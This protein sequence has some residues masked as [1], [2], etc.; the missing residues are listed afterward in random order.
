M[1]KLLALA[2]VG[3]AAAGVILILYPPIVVQLLFGA[4]I[5]GVGMAM[6]RIAGM[7]LLG[8]GVACWPGGDAANRERAWAG[9]L[10]YTMLA[11]L[12]LVY[13]GAVRHLA[14]I[15]LWPA[16]A[17]HVVMGILLVRARR[18]TGAAVFTGETM[19]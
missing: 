9:M 4:E 13:L 1:T 10:T 12:Y 18:N 14:G 8:L 16:A 7:G 19:R 17:A 6:S 2:A 15:L 3:E 5:A 11:A